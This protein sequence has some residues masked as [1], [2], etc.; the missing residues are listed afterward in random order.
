[1]TCIREQS[2][3]APDSII[4]NDNPDSNVISQSNLNNEKQIAP[5][6]STQRGITIREIDDFENASDSIFVNHDSASNVI[7]QNDVHDEKTD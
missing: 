3:K 7:S 4:C 1:M 6:F 5:C 2:A